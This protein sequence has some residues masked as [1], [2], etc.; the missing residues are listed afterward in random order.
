MR[1]AIERRRAPRPLRRPSPSRSD[2]AAISEVNNLATLLRREFVD[3]G[4][5]S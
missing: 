1:H 2:Q 4:A 5:L 3:P